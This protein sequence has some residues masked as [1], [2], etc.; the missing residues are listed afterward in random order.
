MPLRQFWETLKI[1]YMC[2]AGSYTEDSGGKPSLDRLFTFNHETNE[3]DFAPET[4]LK[5][6]KLESQIFV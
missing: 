4:K 2:D 5:I 3:M 6:Q 1:Y